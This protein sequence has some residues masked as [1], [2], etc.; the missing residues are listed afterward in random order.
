MVAELKP[1]EYLLLKHISD[2]QADGKEARENEWT[3]GKEVYLQREK[4]GI[5]TLTATFDVPPEME[6]YFKINY[7]KALEK[8]KTLAEKL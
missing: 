5:T 6:D 1:Y 7:P 2:T 3:G 4:D 8:V